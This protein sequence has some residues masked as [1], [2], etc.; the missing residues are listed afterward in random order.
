M[1]RHA[2]RPLVAVTVGGDEHAA[3]AVLI[4]DRSNLFVVFDGLEVVTFAKSTLGEKQ[5][6]GAGPPQPPPPGSRFA[7]H[8]PIA[9]RNVPALLA[10]ARQHPNHRALRRA[11]FAVVS[12]AAGDEATARALAAS[13]PRGG[14]T[15]ERTVREL[16]PWHLASE[17]VRR[18]AAGGDE[19]SLRRGLARA[20]RLEGTVASA[21]ATEMLAALDLPPPEAPTPATGL[22]AMIAARLDRLRTAACGRPEVDGAADR[23]AVASLRALGESA[24]EAIEHASRDGRLSRCVAG[25]VPGSAFEDQTE[26]CAIDP[27]ACRLGPPEPLRLATVADLARR[28]LVLPK[29]ERAPRDA[30]DSECRGVGD[31]EVSALID[32]AGERKDLA[33]AR[34]SAAHAR[35]W[36]RARLVAAIGSIVGEAEV[37]AFL[38]R[39]A[40]E[41][42]VLAA[43]IEAGAALG[44]RGLHG[45]VPAVAPAVLAALR[46]EDDSAETARRCDHPSV[47]TDG[48]AAL[49]QGGGVDGL[50][51]LDA[52]F[53][54]LGPAGRL[55]VLVQ[56]SLLPAGEAA[57]RDGRDRIFRAALD[58][59]R[60][61]ELPPAL[62]MRSRLVYGCTR[63]SPSDL[64]ATFFASR[65]KLRYSC[66]DS[67]AD[68]ATAI[69]AIVQRLPP[70]AGR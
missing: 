48:L 53:A 19:L 65:T 69:R 63:F 44:R 31:D 1:P 18:Y 12:D 11:V 45:W 32:R 13:V 61:I 67:P 5:G 40:A 25:P 38:A 4:V 17:A 20:R 6:E 30:S 24:R 39:E 47:V 62:P 9:P 41:G 33:A 60:T 36:V 66:A 37:N 15:A 55:R 22:D 8:R 43:R 34:A 54:G 42:P 56:L 49:A 46:A 64:A 2:G 29:G 26:I 21:A 51:A 52:G 23:Q 57:V 58:D 50:A 70:S 14:M 3:P 16:V 28:A 68:K 7:E 59:T 35:G 10:E 27:D